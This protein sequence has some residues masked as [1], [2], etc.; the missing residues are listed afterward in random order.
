MR[1]LSSLPPLQTPLDPIRPSQQATRQQGHHFHL[2][3]AAQIQAMVLKEAAAQ[4]RAR[5]KKDSDLNPDK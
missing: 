5:C 3:L 1:I 4:D 2:F